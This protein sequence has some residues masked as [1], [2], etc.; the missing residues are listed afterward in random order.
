MTSIKETHLYAEVIK[1]FTYP[2]GNVFVFKEFVVSEI[3]EGQVFNWEKAKLIAKDVFSFLDTNGADVIFISNRINS[4]SVV[5]LDWLKFYN[6]Q[7]TLK[8]YCV[9][10]QNKRSILNTRLE[11]LFYAKRIKHFNSIFEA[12]NFIRKGVIEIL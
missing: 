12:V 5:P 3:N 9:V 10:S 11:S 7:Y 6:Q 1:E 2:F 4:Y 8:A